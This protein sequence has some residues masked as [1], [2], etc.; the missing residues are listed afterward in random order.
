[1]ITAYGREEAAE[2]AKDVEF[3][4]ILAKPVTQSTLFD[5]ISS[6][7]GYGVREDFVQERMEVGVPEELDA[8]ANACILLV[9][10]NEI[11]QEVAAGLLENQGFSVTIAND[12]KEAVEKVSAFDFDVVLMDLQMPV[13]GGYEATRNIREWEKRSNIQHPTS[14]IPIIAMTADVVGEVKERCLQAG[15]NDY[16]SKPIDPRELFTALVRWIKPEGKDQVSG[17]G[18]QVSG[19]G[20]TIKDL[21]PGEPLPD[22]PGI[23]VKTALVLVGGNP[24]M[25]KR[26]LRKFATGHADTV[27]KI[28]SALEDKEMEL[29]KRLVHTFKGLAG[30]IGALA[31]SAAATDLE[32]AIKGESEEVNGL[33][34]RVSEALKLVISGIISFEQSQ[35]EDRPAAAVSVESIDISKVAPLLDELKALLDEDDT[36]AVRKLEQVKEALKGSTLQDELATMERLLGEYDFEGVQEELAKIIE[37]IGIG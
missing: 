14:N 36:E 28:A 5:A 34:D 15:M 32:A 11:N 17:V 9:E 18:D 20:E 29:A 13:M 2:A 6:A 26:L 37:K 12:G 8:I 23:D 10:D 33:L 16:V 30:T 3:D 4:E 35:S 19:I 22:L 27:D 25:F 31:L 7:L 24:E 1:M 21:K